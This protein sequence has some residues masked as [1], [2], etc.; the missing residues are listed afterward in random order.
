MPRIAHAVAGGF[1]HHVIQR[2]NNKENVFFND[3]D[4]EKYLY[5]LRKYSVKRGS[6]RIMQNS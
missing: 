3:S 4:R 1:P 2:G 5:L 6:G